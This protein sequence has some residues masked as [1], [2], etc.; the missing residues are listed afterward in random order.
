[1]QDSSPLKDA[2][3]ISLD[4]HCGCL[5][6]DPVYKPHVDLNRLAIV[7]RSRM[8]GKFARPSQMAAQAPA[9][10]TQVGYLIAQ[11][12]TILEIHDLYSHAR[13]RQEAPEEAEARHRIEEALEAAAAAEDRFVS[14]FINDF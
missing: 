1:M 4:A 11:L 2:S 12:M 7:D 3:G 6:C 5:F 10:M 13:P 9:E 14:I 8:L